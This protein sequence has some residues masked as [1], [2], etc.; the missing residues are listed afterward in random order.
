MPDGLRSTVYVTLQM[1]S[2]Q[3]LIWKGGSRGSDT[4]VRQ[5]VANHLKVLNI[6]HPLLRVRTSHALH[7]YRNFHKESID[8]NTL[9]YSIIPE[10]LTYGNS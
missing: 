8:G 9:S 2:S 3:G 1:R 7:N 4:Q 6:L 10:G 5:W